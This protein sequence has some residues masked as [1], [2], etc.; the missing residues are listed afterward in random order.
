ML[1]SL[2]RK[3]HDFSRRLIVRVLLIAAL[4]L[5]ALVLSKLVSGFIPADLDGMVG[6]DAVDNIL[7]IIANSMLAVTTFSLTVMAAAHRNVSSQWTPRAHQILLEDT[8]THTVLATFVGAYLYALAAIILR[9]ME[10]FRD[11]SLVVLFGTTLV[12]VAMIV[13]AIIRWISHM[14]M[15]GSLIETAQRIEDKTQQAF[16]MRAEYPT[17]GAGRLDPAA[18]P[19]EAV[20]IAAPQTGYVQQIYQDLLQE[21]A[22]ATEARVWVLHPVGAFV[23]QGQ[24]L[25]RADSDD[26]TLRDKICANV[27]IGTLRNFD[28]DPDF[29]LTCLGEIAVRALSPGV[30]D[31]GTASDILHRITR[32]LMARREPITVDA[33]DITLDRVFLPPLD[34][35]ALVENSVAPILHDWGA[36]PDL[37][38]PMRETLTALSLHADPEIARVA[39]RLKA[40]ALAETDGH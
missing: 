18:I 13:V 21:A 24:A 30:N 6:A 5:L 26:E 17:L 28:Q 2:L 4:A 10:V 3:A 27:A 9:D 35:A 20:V 14:E 12:V 36:R 19:E 8:T 25:A 33:E 39:R 11:Q 38:R 31:P 40:D 29:G 22:E 32:I 34:R 23:Y 15:L 16:D 1:P 7:S 37:I